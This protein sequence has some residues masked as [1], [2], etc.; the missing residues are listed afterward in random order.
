MSPPDPG[1][2]VLLT[3]QRFIED[4]AGIATQLDVSRYVVDPDLRGQLPGAREGLPEQLFVREHEGELELALYVDPQVVDQLAFDDPH[5]RLHEGNLASYCIALEGVS[6]FVFVAYRA[7]LGRPVTPLE[8]EIQAEVDKFV[9]AWLLLAEQGHDRDA[10]A[11]QLM[12]RMFVDYE[13]HDD[14]PDDH[15]DRYHTAS[16]AAGRFCEALAG[17]YGRDRDAA[18]ITREVRTYYRKG[19]AE[20]LRA[21]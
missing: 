4:L 5:R 2:G 1:A 12:R 15:S 19:L 3:L 8:M 10:A 14:V 18:R 6:H 20:K 16:R 17:R 9:G 11:R 13:L 21:A 7:L